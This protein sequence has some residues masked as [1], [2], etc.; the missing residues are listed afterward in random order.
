MYFNYVLFSCAVKSGSIP[1]IDLLLEYGAELN[2]SK[3]LNRLARKHPLV[4]ALETRNREVI[5]HIVAKGADMKMSFAVL[6]HI[7]E[8]DLYRALNI[9]V[10]LEL[11][12]ISMLELQETPPNFEALHVGYY[13]LVVIISWWNYYFLV[14]K[15]YAFMDIHHGESSINIH[16]ET[17]F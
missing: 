10:D 5:K 1:C 15:I 8:L 13:F 7:N 6:S 11:S 17:S 3:H 9:R 4:C 12:E 16:G 14:V 2:P